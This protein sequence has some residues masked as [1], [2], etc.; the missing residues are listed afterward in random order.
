MTQIIS[1]KI[2]SSDFNWVNR[3]P[4]NINYLRPN[5]FRFNV[6]ILPTVSYFCQSVS[7][8]ELTL[9]VATQPTPLVDIPRP[10][11]KL[12]FGSLTIRFM[13][14]E[15]LQNY[16]ELYNWM[17]GLAPPENDR[18]FRAFH[19][20][21]NYKNADYH[22]TD[23]TDFSDASLT[24]LGSDNIPVGR[25]NFIDCFPTSLSGLDFDVSAGSTQYFQATATFRYTRFAIETLL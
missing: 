15:N 8:P 13:I 18:Q 2:K 25:F 10:G 1:E 11:E 16:N 6:Q 22:K 20:D 17:V 4:E 14:Q 5:G 21:K 12:T 7:L 19:E 3:Q 9:G 24:V 23:L